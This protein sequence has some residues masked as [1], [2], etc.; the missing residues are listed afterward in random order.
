MHEL[1]LLWDTLSVL[2]W[3]RLCLQQVLLQENRCESD[4][5]IGGVSEWMDG[6][7]ISFQKV[8]VEKETKKIL[9]KKL[10]ETDYNNWVW[11]VE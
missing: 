10:Q 4:H 1:I 9:K 7:S 11:I 5:L 2:I 8:M 3:L 6:F